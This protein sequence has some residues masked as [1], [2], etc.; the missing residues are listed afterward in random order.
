MIRSHRNIKKHKIAL[1]LEVIKESQFQEQYM[2]L[3]TNPNCLKF[4]LKK[5][6]KEHPDQ[7]EKESKRPNSIT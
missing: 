6:L 1:E 5:C 2:H 3:I 7:K 4:F